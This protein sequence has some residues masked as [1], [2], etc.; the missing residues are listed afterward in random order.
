[1]KAYFSVALCVCFCLPI[2]ATG[3]STKLPDLNADGTKT[4]L[5]KGWKVITLFTDTDDRL[6]GLYTYQADSVVSTPPDKIKFWIKIKDY[7]QNK[8]D[9]TLMLYEMKCTSREVRT[10]RIVRHFKD[11]S[12]AFRDNPNL[13][14][15]DVEPASLD[16]VVMNVV[17]KETG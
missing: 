6:I 16:E 1:M 13:R 8:I 5:E 10:G 9:Y 17:C 15:A 14:F 2:L 11:K 7:R 4:V 12:S 3:Q